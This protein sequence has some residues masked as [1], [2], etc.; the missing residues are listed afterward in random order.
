ML[1]NHSTA[2]IDCGTSQNN[3]AIEISSI[4]VANIEQGDGE[5]NHYLY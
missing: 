3:H 5:T 4:D 2:H 1:P